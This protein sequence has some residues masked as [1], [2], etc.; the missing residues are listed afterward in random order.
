VQLVKGFRYTFTL[1]VPA[2]ADF[3]LY[4]Y[5]GTGTAYGEPV[6][7]ANSTT[8]TTGGTEQITITSAPYTGT[9]YL[10]VKRATETTGSGT[11]TLTSSGPVYV[12]LNTPGLPSASNVVHYTQNSV[13]KT[14]S[15]VSSTFSDYADTGTTLSID[16]PISVSSTERYYTTDTTSFTITSSATFTVNYAHQY[17]IQ[18]NSAHDSPTP[19][20][21]VNQGSGLTVSVTSPADDDGMGT[22]YRCT[23]YTLDSNPPVTDGSTTYTFNNVQSAHTIT[24]NWIAQYKLLVSINPSGLSPA[25]DVNPM[26]PDGFYDAGTQVTLIANTVNS[27]T[28]NYWT[29]DS[30]NQ[31]TGKDMITVIMSAPHSAI[32]YYAPF[33]MNGYFTDS[34]FNPIDSFDCVFTVSTGT[35]YKMAATNPGTYYY[36]LKITNN[37]ASGTFTIEVDIPS[38]FILKPLVSGANPVQINGQPVSYII[39]G[40]GNGNLT[41]LNV[42][43]NTGQTVTLTVHMDYALKFQYTGQAPYTANDQLTYRKG[44]LF[45]TMVNAVKGSAPTIVAAGKKVTAIG[46][47][48]TDS[49]GVSKGGLTVKVFDSSSNLMGTCTS[50]ED[51]FYFIAVLPGNSYTVKVYDSLG[52]VKATKNSVSVAQDQ[53]VS[54]DFK[55]LSPAD[56]A[57]QGFV[58]D[59]NGTPLA[60]VTVQLIDVSGRVI[61]T[62]T[63][64]AGGHYIF[65]F[66]APGTYTVRVLAPNGTTTST[67]VKVAQFQTATVN[68][69]LK[70]QT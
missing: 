14:G 51:G 10:V 35:K 45:P 62:T 48:L 15:I 53:Y 64:N 70:E 66:S 44:Y 12:T 8:A 34:D 3:D 38:D 6:I 54:V 24:F 28:F 63:T 4:L 65:R 61:A 42:A 36:N 23:G 43:I 1:S 59:S 22:R 18:V 29:V 55:E 11:F 58:T 31:G 19:S 69:Q 68:F 7:V 49:N 17:W 37:G 32:A 16:N 41:I 46:G 9:Y 5:N 52:N 20:Q 39:S 2:G 40:N 60:G 13:S 56:P 27:Y 33:T 57:I 47:F 30:N 67:T 50:S 25:P 26:S 21:W